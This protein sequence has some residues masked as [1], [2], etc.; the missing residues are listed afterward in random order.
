MLA[1]AQW[2]THTHQHVLT[3]RGTTQGWCTKCLVGLTKV[4]HLAHFRKNIGL[5]L[6]WIR[7]LV[8]L[9]KVFLIRFAHKFT[10]GELI[11]ISKQHISYWRN[12]N[13]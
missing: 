13:L 4:T 2:S 3:S 11:C 9:C 6:D 1:L 12:M 8:Q 5:N 10:Y 7:N